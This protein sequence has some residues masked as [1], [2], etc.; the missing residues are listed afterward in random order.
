MITPEFKTFQPRSFE[1]VKNW[2][3]SNQKITIRKNENFGFLSNI[4]IWA[5]NPATQ[6]KVCLNGDQTWGAYWDGYNFGSSIQDSL[7]ESCQ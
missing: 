2:L 4:V 7:H 1:I 5:C 3:N 6:E